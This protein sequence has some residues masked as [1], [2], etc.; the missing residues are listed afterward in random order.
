MSDELEIDPE[1]DKDAFSES[2][3]PQFVNLLKNK[4][5]ICKVNSIKL[6]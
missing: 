6:E 5:E 2:L 1:E 3:R 4:S